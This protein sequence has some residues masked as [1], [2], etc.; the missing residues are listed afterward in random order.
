MEEK[1][2]A[3]LQNLQEITYVRVSFLMKLQALGL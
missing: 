1:R 2:G 3:I